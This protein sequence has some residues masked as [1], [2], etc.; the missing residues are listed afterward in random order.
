M[1]SSSSDVPLRVV[2]DVFI[3]QL[4]NAVRG[5]RRKNF[6]NESIHSIRKELKR[7]RATLRLLRPSI[8]AGAYHRENF[9]WA[10]V[11]FQREAL[12]GEAER[13]GRNPCALGDSIKCYVFSIS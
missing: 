10:G 1:K 13:T 7:A 4:N 3:G 12:Q 6:S 2:R 11:C 8:G 5:F 9:D